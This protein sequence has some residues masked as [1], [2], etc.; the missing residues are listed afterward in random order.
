MNPKLLKSHNQNIK[1]TQK[2]VGDER[3]GFHIETGNKSLSWTVRPE[4]KN[5][6][7]SQDSIKYYS[8]LFVCWLGVFLGTER[9][10]KPQFWNDISFVLVWW[11]NL[12][13]V[14]P[15]GIYRPDARESLHLNVLQMLLFQPLKLWR[16]QAL[17]KFYVVPL[18]ICCLESA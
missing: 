8:D 7:S 12:V 2:Y 18:F 3:L 5:W 4:I 14:P 11:Q 9:S 1:K 10:V 13:N 15:W 16:V 6:Y 17:H